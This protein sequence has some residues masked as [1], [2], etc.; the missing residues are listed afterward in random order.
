MGCDIVTALGRATAD[1]QTIFGQNISWRTGSAHPLYRVPGRD[2]ARGEKI[3]ADYLE[4]PQARRTYTVLGSRPIS[5]WGY[6]HGVNEHGV[7]AGCSVYRNKKLL[8]PKPGLSGPDLVRL[9]LERAESA[10][11]AVELITDLV[12]RH[13]Q[14]MFP[15]C[16]AE[17]AGDHLFLI[18][19]PTQAFVVEAA[20]NHWVYQEVREVRAVSNVCT[21]RQ[22]WNRISPGLSGYVITEGWWPADGSKLDFTEALCES[23][24][25]ENSALR[26]WG[27]AT[28]LLEQQNG[29]IDEAF[30][31]RLLSDH[32]E[33]THYEVDPLASFHGP[34]PLCRHPRSAD[35]DATV[36]SLVVSL[37]RNSERLLTASCAFGP[38]CSSVYFPIFLDGDL[39]KPYG[40]DETESA[41]DS[42]AGRMRRLH[43]RLWSDP[44]AWSAIHDHLAHLQAE[45]DQETERIAV[46]GAAL[47]R[48]GDLPALQRVV[49]AFMQHNLERFDVVLAEIEA[50]TK[51]QGPDL[52]PVSSIS[53]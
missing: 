4:L 1:G 36:A 18:A 51:A 13:G 5:C 9:A 37:V 47:K 27:R 46:E 23:S 38:P 25:G 14:G 7:A 15:G 34:M 49:G 8:S 6:R 41:S 28:Y 45:F 53:G 35:G 43:E 10:S 26:R 48:N 19:D 42:L 32:Y 22:D 12:E 17:E 39:P 20:A 29:H 16:P 33:G 11:Q 50:T 44:E 40:S 52:R 31:R 21:I 2:F 3:R 30:V 24:L